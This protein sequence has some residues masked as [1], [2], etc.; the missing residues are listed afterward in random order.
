MPI[1]QETLL[2]DHMRQTMERFSLEECEEAIKILQKRSNQLNNK[3]Y[4]SWLTKSIR[5]LN[6]SARAE[7]ALFAV[8]IQTMGDIMNWGLDRIYFIKSCGELTSL[9]IKE[10]V[11]KDMSN[12]H[13]NLQ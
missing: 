5:D 7:N 6:L 4:Q 3:D 12:L 10:A 13:G 8:N 1:K 9:Q 2:D 11:L